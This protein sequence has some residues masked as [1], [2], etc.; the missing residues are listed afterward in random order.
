MQQD[1]ELRDLARALAAFRKRGEARYP[2]KLRA[3]IT[4]WVISQRDRGEWW[5][6]LSAALGLPTETLVR[7]AD[8]G[9]VVASEMKAVDVIDT[10][11]IGTVTL[12]SPTGLR[13]EGVSIDAAIAILRGLA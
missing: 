3:R 7:W 13:I 2:A 8:M 10:P 9:R 11:P 6:D 5:T 12:V 1:R 4:T